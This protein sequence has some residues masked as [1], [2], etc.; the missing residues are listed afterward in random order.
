M[1]LY[2]LE[3]EKTMAIPIAPTPV[4][5]GKEA[6]DFEKTIRANEAKSIPIKEI[7]NTIKVFTKVLD[8]KE[9]LSEVPHE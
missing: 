1:V 5:K 3:G 6:K 9:K 2:I 4:L 8:S 7:R